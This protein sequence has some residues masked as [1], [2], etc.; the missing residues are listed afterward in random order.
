MEPMLLLSLA[1]LPRV[2]PWVPEGVLLVAELPGL[3]VLLAVEPEALLPEEGEA[4]EVEDTGEPIEPLLPWVLL[5]L[6]LEE[7]CCV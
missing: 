5:P 7:P 2:E 1:L 6:L 4:E 3:P